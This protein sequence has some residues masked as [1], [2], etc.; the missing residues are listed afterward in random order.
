QPYE[1]EID[2]LR[3]INTEPLPMDRSLLRNST[4]EDWVRE[5]KFIQD[6]LT[7]EVIDQAFLTVP[8]EVGDA[9]VEKIIPLLKSRLERL[10]TTAKDY[11]KILDRV[12]I[13]H[14]T[15]KD[16]YIEVIRTA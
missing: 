5:A 2:N 10:V 4:Q 13:L 7:E 15:D 11:Y 1:S 9:T 6:H 8:K 12:A 16:D 3:W 14:A